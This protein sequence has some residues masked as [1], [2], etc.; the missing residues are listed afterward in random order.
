MT[1]LVSVL[2]KK[3]TSPLF[4]T[5]WGYNDKSHRQT[6]KSEHQIPDELVPWPT[7]GWSPQP[8]E[9][10]E[11]SICCLSSPVC[12]I[13]L[14]EITKNWLGEWLSQIVQLIIMEP[15]F[16]SQV[17]LQSLLFSLQKSWNGST[18]HRQ[19]WN[20]HLEIVLILLVGGLLIGRGLLVLCEG[21]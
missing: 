5:T 6:R 21:A 9:L 11:I 1:G 18:V 16:K 13:Q 7:R 10:W 12:G 14:Q 20:N 2:G 17:W 15:E 4:S 19:A 3:E 8:P